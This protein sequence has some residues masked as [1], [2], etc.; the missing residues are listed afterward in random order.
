MAVERRGLA[1]GL[2]LW[3]DIMFYLVLVVGAAW[4]FLTPVGALGRNAEWDVTLPVAVGKNAFYPILT[5]EE[6][7]TSTPEL[8]H[9]RL[10]KARGELRVSSSTLL[11]H[12]GL[13]AILLPALGVLVWG[14]FLL[15]KILATSASGHPFHPSNPERLNT[16][17]W[18][19]VAASVAS[20][21]VEYL[22]GRWMLSGVQ[23]A[24][25]PIAPSLQ[26]HGN[27]IF[28][29]LL[30]LV[31]AAIWKEAVR[32]AEEQALTV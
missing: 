25:V 26:I 4:L 29:G 20:T 30:I 32:M 6:E 2:K 5:L 21:L 27:W 7:P 19:I 10:V 17:G 15:R 13:S 24:T 9:L 14:L 1:R 18:L 8:S 16:L 11:H 22:A 3:L 28:C 12:F 31:L 23:V